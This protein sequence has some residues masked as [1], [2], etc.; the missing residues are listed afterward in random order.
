MAYTPST[1]LGS[2]S[3]DKDA[4]STVDSNAG[5]STRG[6]NEKL[7]SHLSFPA[8]PVTISAYTAIDSAGSGSTDS[9]AIAAAKAPS[10]FSC[11]SPSHIVERFLFLYVLMRVFTLHRI[12]MMRMP[13][14]SSVPVTSLD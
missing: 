4:G 13:L 3:D 14:S 6:S 1:G 7:T 5:E 10:F 11:L 12:G 9:T 2:L 8:A